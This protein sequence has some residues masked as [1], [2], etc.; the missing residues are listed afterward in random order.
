M[1][2]REILL[3]SEARGHVLALRQAGKGLRI[4]GL[5]LTASRQQKTRNHHRK[6]TFAMQEASR[7][8]A[9]HHRHCSSSSFITAPPSFCRL[10]SGYSLLRNDHVR[11]RVTVTMPASVRAGSI[12]FER[13]LSHEPHAHRFAHGGAISI[14]RFV[15]CRLMREPSAG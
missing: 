11:P 13:T 7:D 8:R 6:P 4:G 1:Y 5:K 14:G 9:R 3:P 12:R 2:P 15:S 10:I